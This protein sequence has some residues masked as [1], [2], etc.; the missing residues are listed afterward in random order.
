M[1]SNDFRQYK[2]PRED[3]R[4]TY[5]ARDILCFVT[6][7]E[8]VESLHKLLSGCIPTLEPGL[9]NLL[10]LPLF[11][12][13][14]QTSQQMVFQPTPRNTRKCVIST[15]LVETSITLPGLRFVVDCG[16]SKQKQFRATLGLSSLLVKPISKSSAIQRSGMS[17]EL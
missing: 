7:Q 17:N 3:L 4:R 8:T 6:G 1:L 15:N 5:I 9:P 16:L 14:S 10:V 11:S 12:A 2:T 13:L